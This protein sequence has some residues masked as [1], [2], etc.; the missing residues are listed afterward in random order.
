MDNNTEFSYTEE[1]EKEYAKSLER[2]VKSLKQKYEDERK[3][4][5]N[6]R[7]Q[8]DQL[9]SEL[10]ASTAQCQSA[11]EQVEKL[12]G[13]VKKTTEQLQK[14]Q[15]E[16]VQLEERCHQLGL[17]ASGVDQ[18][19]IALQNSNKAL[20]NSQFR[21]REK[22]RQLDQLTAEHETTVKALETAQSRIKYLEARVEDL[23]YQVMQELIKN[24]KIEK[25]IEGV[26][27][28]EDKI[29]E[30]D[31]LVKQQEKEVKE[32]CA[33]LTASRKAV[34]EYKEKIRSHENQVREV[35]QVREE[36]ELYK[37]EV[38]TL[39]KLLAG[40][41]GLVLQK[42]QALDFA[43]DVI[44][45]LQLS[46]DGDNVEKIQQLI[47]RSSLVLSSHNSNSTMSLSWTA[48]SA[49]PES[50]F[51][52]TSG[53]VVSSSQKHRPW[54]AVATSRQ[55]KP[56]FGYHGNVA[57][58]NPE[59][60]IL[61]RLLIEDNCKENCHYSHSLRSSFGLGGKRPNTSHGMPSREAWGTGTRKLIHRNEEQNRMRYRPCSDTSY[62]AQQTE[63][64][65]VY[66]MTNLDNNNNDTGQVKISS[67]VK[68]II[69]ERINKLSGTKFSPCQDDA[70]LSMFVDVGDRVFVKFPN[71]L[72]PQKLSKNPM[73]QRFGKR[74]ATREK[75]YCGIVKYKGLIERDVPDSRLYVGLNLDEPAGDTDGKVRDKTYM[76]TSPEHGKF[77]RIL[78]IVSV[79]DIQS[80]R[81][82]ELSALKKEY[83]QHKENSSH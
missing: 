47:E 3:E 70:I 73:L 1:Q 57:C 6:L 31:R 29:L 20:D 34:R 66:H 40:K 13:E 22:E 42:S 12:R 55:A 77:L 62:D 50:E 65:T 9:S 46:L 26:P 5:Q 79:F 71:S 38:N 75:H 2:Q 11:S 72:I 8:V 45:T 52:M 81:Y 82:I 51:V 37:H 23:N 15:R 44:G 17:R 54:T 36:L 53:S 80:S 35:K 39:K 74:K 10:N 68:R 49:S 19:E 48:R 59:N 14:S 69:S 21:L 60:G 58:G 33:L 30:L 16:Q 7:T 61:E 78:N 4:S 41:D 25:K 67:I 27:L 76:F 28:L 56:S 64:S 18:T 83:L 63:S 24:E 43:K 32:K